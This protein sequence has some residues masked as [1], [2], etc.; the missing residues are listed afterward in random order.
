MQQLGPLFHYYEETRLI[1]LGPQLWSQSLAESKLETQYFDLTLFPGAWSSDLNSQSAQS[2][3]RSMQESGGE[4][5]DL[6]AALGYD[7]VRFS[8][9]VG[10]GQS[11]T[12]AFNQALA[13]AANRMSWSLAPMHW[14]AGRATQDLF[15]FQ[16]TESGM[17]L[18]DMEKMRQTREQ[19]QTRRE[20]RRI[21]LET[22]KQ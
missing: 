15:L 13:Q 7:F 21:Q 20:E 14:D 11:S 8:A 3:K 5:T 1:F 9:L 19:R 18:A 2:L 4:E 16:P 17:V 10:G 12:E 22:K 6:W